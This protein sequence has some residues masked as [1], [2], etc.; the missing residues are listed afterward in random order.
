MN[1]KNIVIVVLVLLIIGAM[2]Y[3]FLSGKEE[4]ASN[5]PIAPEESIVENEVTPPADEVP[6]VE[7]EER[8]KETIIGS[9]VSGKEI[10]AYHFGT[11]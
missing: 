11:G 4:K 2:T 3:L 9:S 5:E 10:V 8:G 1:T 6:V 7:K